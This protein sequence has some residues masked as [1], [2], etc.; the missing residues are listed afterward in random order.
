MLARSCFGCSAT[1]NQVLRCLSVGSNTNVGI[2]ERMRKF[3]ME[4]P[5][6]SP[7][8]PSNLNLP[9][10]KDVSRMQKEMMAQVEV[11]DIDSIHNRL[12]K[13]RPNSKENPL[14]VGSKLERQV[15]TCM[16]YPDAHYLRH[17]VLYRDLPVRCQCG[18]WFKLVDM[19]RFEEEREKRWAEIK[20]EPENAKLLKE[21]DDTEN[22]LNT[23]MARSQSMTR[24][25]PGSNDA[26]IELSTLWR[27]LKNTYVEIRRRMD[28]P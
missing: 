25:S 10:A 16:C 5:H 17:I 11:I 3:I 1:A 15:E 27:K 4:N 24:K 8:G 9:V 23:L 7:S 13:I 26:I 21:L 2:K 19:K 14:I 22:A 18:H 20:N 6:L 28:L 12:R